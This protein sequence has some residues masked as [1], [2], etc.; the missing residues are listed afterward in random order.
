MKTEFIEPL[1]LKTKIPINNTNLPFEIW[2]MKN[3]NITSIKLND[4]IYQN[5]GHNGKQKETNTEKEQVDYLE[6]IAEQEQ[7][8]TEKQWTNKIIHIKPTDPNKT[9]EPSEPTLKQRR[10]NHVKKQLEKYH[11]TKVSINTI[12]KYIKDF[13]EYENRDI[14]PHTLRTYAD[15]AMT[16]LIKNHKITFKRT[17]KPGDFIKKDGLTT[18]FL[19]WIE[20]NNIKKFTLNEF[21]NEYPYITYNQATKI[22][23]HQIQNNTIWQNDK[24][25]FTVTKKVNT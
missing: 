20:N 2:E 16:Y 13:Y 7:K 1:T 3:G 11:R 4:Q 12:Q 10:I 5:N 9:P 24:E 25:T 6:Q 17:K 18:L 21:I 14:N 19:H 8:N 23:S 15:Q 22:M